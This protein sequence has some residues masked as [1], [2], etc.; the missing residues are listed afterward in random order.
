M[1]VSWFDGV[2]LTLEV[3]LSAS[4]GASGVWDTG[5]WDTATWG[6]DVVWT[7]VTAYLRGI[8]TSRSFDRNL[9]AWQAG[10]ASF[11]LANIDGRFSPSNMASP[12][13]TGGITGVRP[14]R[15]VRFRAS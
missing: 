10:T 2:T 6:P 8:Q 14:W 13:V 9:A 12:Y 1:P 3:A 5:V 7:D 11:V 4:T 15:P